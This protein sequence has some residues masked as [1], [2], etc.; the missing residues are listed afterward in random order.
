MRPTRVWHGTPYYER[1]VADPLWIAEPKVDGDRCLAFVGEGGV[2][3]W[4]RHGRPHG[5]GWLGPLQDALRGLPVGTVLD[6]ELLAS[7]TPR[8]EYVV[9]DL[10]SEYALPLASR[11]RLL[12]RLLRRRR[13]GISIA[14]WLDDKIAAYTSSLASGHEGIVLKQTKSTYQWQRSTT[15]ETAV[16]CKVKKL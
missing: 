6:G 8:A 2:E 1:L 9:F 7:P 13:S 16:W 11:R 15:G 10:A 5:Y 14:P 12:E 3:L 4:S